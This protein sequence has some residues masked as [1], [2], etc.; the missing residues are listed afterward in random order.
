VRS[1]IR[2]VS[3]RFAFR[4]CAATLDWALFHQCAL[5]LENQVVGEDSAEDPRFVVVENV[6]PLALGD[7]LRVKHRFCRFGGVET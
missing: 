3:G 7:G 2:S 5:F 1:A 4:D 6:E